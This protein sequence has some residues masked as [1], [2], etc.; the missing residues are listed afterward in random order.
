MA[1]TL[2]NHVCGHNER[3]A[4]PLRV[5]ASTSTQSGSSDCE[6]VSEGAAASLWVVCF[7]HAVQTQSPKRAPHHDCVHK[8]L[9]LYTTNFWYAGRDVFFGIKFAI[10][11]TNLYYP[12]SC[13]LA[14]LHVCLSVSR[15]T[16]Y[17]KN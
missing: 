9:Q 11:I 6:W 3:L 13:F 4:R 7:L 5:A 17:L 12:S 10:S 15:P 2:M 1:T 8:K 16:E 14:C